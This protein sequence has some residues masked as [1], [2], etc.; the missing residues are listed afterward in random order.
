[1]Q[2]YSAPSLAER[3]SS[4]SSYSSPVPTPA[5]PAQQDSALTEENARLNTEL[6]EAYAKIRGLELE[7][8]GV[9]AN[10][11]RAAQALLEG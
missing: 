8:E 9:R 10:A 7:L 6:R 5:A 3:T 11:R 4:Y 2:S 1:M